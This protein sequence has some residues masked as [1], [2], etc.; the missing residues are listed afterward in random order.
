LQ[1]NTINS[2]QQSDPVVYEGYT[3][4]MASF[5]QT[6]NPNA[7]KVTNASVVGVPEVQEGKQLVVK[8]GGERIGQGD[9]G[10]LQGRCG[11]WLGVA[12]KVPI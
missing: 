2:V 7:H 6:G 11:F 5:I 3:G 10:M 1:W 9:V 12:G 4:A 8:S